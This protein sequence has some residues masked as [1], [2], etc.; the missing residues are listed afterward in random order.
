M[1]CLL[2]SL[3]DGTRR[4]VECPSGEDPEEVAEKH[5]TTIYE[6]CSSREEAERRLAKDPT[7]KL[8]FQ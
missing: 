2:L 6:F 7:G 5:G 4:I 1:S 3:P 8:D